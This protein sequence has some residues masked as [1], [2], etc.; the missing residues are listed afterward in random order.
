MWK[1]RSRSAPTGGDERA[2]QAAA[3]LAE[4]QQARQA[5]EREAELVAARHARLA[6]GTADGTSRSGALSA[7]LGDVAQVAADVVQEI[8]VLRA[9]M[10]EMLGQVSALREVS[11]QI[12]PI[13]HAIRSIAKQTN[14]LALNATIEAA[15]AG[16]AGQGFAVVAAEVRKLADDSGSA[17]RSIDAIV[18]EMREMTALTLEIATTTS[19]NLEQYTSHFVTVGDRLDGAQ[20]ELSGLT[21]DLRELLESDS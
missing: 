17:T 4:E 19:D 11:D 6:R 5:V 1:R 18:A 8:D 2:Q 13:V 14:L 12:T 10:F 16:A 21:F 20:A 9:G 15:R 3:R 7:E